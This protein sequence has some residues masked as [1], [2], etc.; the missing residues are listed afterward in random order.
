M[1]DALTSGPQVQWADCHPSIL[2]KSLS[3]DLTKHVSCSISFQLS[4]EDFLN[5]N[6]SFFLIYTC[7]VHFLC[8]VCASK[9]TSK[10][11]QKLLKRLQ[12][13]QNLGGLLAAF[14][15]YDWK[16]EEWSSL[17]FSASFSQNL[18][19]WKSAVA[20]ARLNTT[21]V[22][23]CMCLCVCARHHAHGVHD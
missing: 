2:C 23:V 16:L 7:D 18:V 12:K 4:P 14:D 22:S 11:F 20:M 15:N 10:R 1:C 21:C 19:F 13:P 17:S 8:K 5:H 6:L 3:S 9:K